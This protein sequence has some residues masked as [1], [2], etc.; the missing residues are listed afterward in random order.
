MCVGSTICMYQNGS[1][2]SM[3]QQFTTRD[4]HRGLNQTDPLLPSVNTAK[5]FSQN[6]RHDHAIPSSVSATKPGEFTS[7]EFNPAGE[8][9]QLTRGDDTDAN[10]V[11]FAEP[12]IDITP[13]CNQ[14]YNPFPRTKGF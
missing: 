2:T 10:P 4:I 6:T 13:T 7:T 14:H 3:T 5:R 1:G 12:A 8:F 9:T 11:P